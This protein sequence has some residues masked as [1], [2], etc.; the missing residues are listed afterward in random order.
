M[1]YLG[2]FPDVPDLQGCSDGGC[3]FRPPTGMHTNGG[4]A[5]MKRGADP[6]LLQRNLQRI[7]RHMESMRA[8]RDALRALLFECRDW[9]D[10]GRAQ[11]AAGIERYESGDRRAIRAARELT[12]CDD[13]LLRIDAAL[14][15]KP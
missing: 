14:G 3:V 12:M 6:L 2:L 8:E 15:E 9:V 11:A 1:K 4:C 10:N 5:C 13:L 7:S